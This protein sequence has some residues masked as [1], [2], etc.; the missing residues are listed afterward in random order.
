MLQGVSQG[1]QGL[2][3]LPPL[4]HIWRE[5]V[6]SRWKSGSLTPAPCSSAG[7]LHVGRAGHR[8]KNSAHL[9]RGLTMA[10]LW[11][12]SIVEQRTPCLRVLSNTVEAL[13]EIKRQV[14]LIQEKQQSSQEYN[15]EKQE[16]DHQGE[17]SWD[18]S[19]LRGSRNLSGTSGR[20]HTPPAIRAGG[21]A[22]L[23]AYQ[24][25]HRLSSTGRPH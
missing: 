10:S 24:V 20:H 13:V 11:Y 9:P 15:S 22:D 8:T 16:T 7:I 4:A 21:G 5:R 6:F 18:H 17:P 1:E 23:K 25:S 2:P 19:Q 3:Q 14:T 12:L